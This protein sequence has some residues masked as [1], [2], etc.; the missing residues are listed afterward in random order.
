MVTTLRKV[1]VPLV[2]LVLVAAAAL[3]LFGGEDRK[4]LT[5]SFPRTI[6]IYEGSDVRVLGVTVGQVEEV[7]PSGTDVQ[8]TL[9]YDAD[10]QVPA[11]ASAL[12]VSPAIVGDRY[13]QLAPAYS[14][15]EVL[16]DG[17]VLDISRTEVPLELDDVYAGIDE[18]TVALGPEGANESGALSDLLV[19][20]AENFAGQGPAFNQAIRDFSQLSRTL[21]DNRE[22]LFGAGRQLNAFLE[23]LADND[24]TVRD[25]ND[26]LAQV[27]DL[28]ADERGDLAASL[29]NLGTAL[30]E[31][32]DFVQDN[33]ALLGE[34]IAGLNRVT[35]ILVR[36]RG[37]LDEI[38]RVAPVALN[39]LALT[40]NPQAGTLDTRANPSQLAGELENNPAL[41]LCTAINQIDSSG[42]LCDALQGALPRAGAL[43]GGRAAAPEPERFDPTLSGL[44]EVQR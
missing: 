24:T 13:V 41:I 35:K 28:L 10:V 36:Q 19:Q 16:A 29:D 25:F 31:V 34:N 12:I 20:T 39:N 26:S 38:L 15:G 8:V 30:V 3:T 14:G 22:E 7:V 43:D 44:V 42:A 23:T 21:D 5:A 1:L 17:A 9:S 6:A 11:D 27:S 4:T 40:Y 32:K 18:L 37:A 2:V 33:R